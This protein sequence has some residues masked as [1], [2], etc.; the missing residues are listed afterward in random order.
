[1]Q[2]WNV[3]L[4]GKNIDTVFFSKSTTA[5]EVYDSLVRHRPSALVRHDSYNP[6]I[7]VRRNN[8]VKNG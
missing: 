2:A 5:A 7:K 1:M 4:N 3:Y 8:L 6:N